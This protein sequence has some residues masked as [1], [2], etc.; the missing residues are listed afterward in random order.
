MKFP[1]LRRFVCATILLG[2]GAGA[3]PLALALTDSDGDPG[4][5]H[6]RAARNRFAETAL[7]PG[8]LPSF[9]RMAGMSQEVSPEDVVPLLARNLALYGFEDAKQTEFL[10]LLH[11]Y[12][13][14]AREIRSLVDRDG[15]IRVSGCDDALRLIAVL[16]YKMQGSCGHRGFA[17]LTADAERAFLTIDSGFPLTALERALQRSEPFAYNFPASRVPILFTE[18]EWVGLSNQRG[19]RSIELV[20]ALLQDQNLDRL[21]WAFAKCDSETRIALQQAPGLRKLLGVVP[22]FELYGSELRVH[23][24]QVEVPGSAVG[25]WEKLIGERPNN[26]GPFVTELLSKD[27]GWLGAFFDVIS[28]LNRDQQIQLSRDDRLQRLY[29]SYRAGAMRT[30]ATNGV[31]P[32]DA[33][34]LMF[35]TSV[36]W[37]ENGEPAIPGTLAVW[38]DVFSKRNSAERDW[39][40]RVRCCATPDQLLE[41]LAANSHV[42]SEDGPVPI[43]LTLSALEAGRSNGH[44]FSDET[45]ELIASKHTE[46]NRWFPIFAEFPALDDAAVV[47]FVKAADRVDAIS[48]PTLHANALGAFQAE[49]GL[50]Q[51]FARQ[52]EI[53]EEKLNSSWVGTVHPYTGVTTSLQLFDAARSSLQSMLSAVTGKTNATQDEI[54]DSLA[55]P[56]QEVP[57]A[58]RV[59]VEMAGRIRA[60]MDDQ[61]LASLD[62][63]F[64]LYDGLGAME[65]GADVGKSLLA[66]AG[67]L[68]EFEMPRPIFTGN[69]RTTWSPLVYTRRHAELQVRTDL[70]RVIQAASPSQLEAAR[71]ELTPFLRDTLVGL[72]YAYYEPPGAE[73]LHKN[74]LFVR[75]HDF[76]SIS[77]LGS[78][79]MWNDSNLMGVGATAGGGAYLIGSLANLPYALAVTE[80]E[81]IAPK[82]VQALIWQA[83]VPDL[84]VDSVLPRWWSVTPNEL[85]AVA[86]YQRVGDDLFVAA[87]DDVPLR[88]K[89]VGILSARMT[90][91][92]LERAEGALH[93]EADS[94]S[95]QLLP[96]EAFYLAVEFRKQYASDFG[97]WSSAAKELDAFAQNSPSDTDPEKLAKDF[98][99]PHSALLFTDTRGLLNMRPPPAFGGNAS[100]LLAQSWESDNL[101]W[102]RLADEKGYSPAM[103]N[104]LIPSLTRRM[105]VNVFATNIDDW[106]ALSRA[107]RETGEEFR[108][109]KIEAIGL[110]DIAGNE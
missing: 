102:A 4:A 14:L 76:S 2:L 25:D 27:H 100:R 11:R 93:G 91:N 107:M 96:S 43:F 35:L 71:A 60:V 40:K 88:A 81:L 108:A 41:S 24:G 66:F 62:T 45:D 30:N 44:R 75:S 68:R 17:L 18:K 79:K 74:P 55:G 26:P 8:P 32:K 65:H 34:L 16:G 69:E 50:W 13:H 61:R 77:I 97:N 85:H 103:L 95:S 109:G 33:N 94:T 53:P 86:L 49:I 59:H 48:N 12:V 6:R 19:P 21:Y 1:L 39:A 15:T 70:A 89:V 67:D 9:L 87:E 51:I 38:Q 5:A 78:Q 46:F 99:V 29:S 22:A 31:F 105:V 110:A 72:N 64:G 54:I 83:V 36:K 47:Q 58:K 28:R 101:Y 7:I 56:H 23:G 10:V 98:G 42:E 104:L 92:R 84:L 106:P 63:L 37:K 20:D 80:S 82:H 73:V 90:S 52:G 57:D 3:S